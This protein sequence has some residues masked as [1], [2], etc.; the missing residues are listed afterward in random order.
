MEMREMMWMNLFKIDRPQEGAAWCL[1]DIQA[2]DTGCFIWQLLKDQHSQTDNRTGHHQLVVFFAISIFVW[3][4]E[5]PLSVLDP[6]TRKRKSSHCKNVVSLFPAANPQTCD[7]IPISAL[8]KFCTIQRNQIG[9]L[10]RRKMRCT[11][12]AF[13]P[14]IFFQQPST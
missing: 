3:A 5:M 1:F 13:F 2:A 10:N 8:P 11:T 9:P 7:P 14:E 12:H 4:T 6:P